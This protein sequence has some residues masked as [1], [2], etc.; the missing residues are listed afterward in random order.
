MASPII[1]HCDLFVCFALVVV[2]PILGV[3]WELT[4]LFQAVRSTFEIVS[5]SM[6]FSK[7]KTVEHYYH[8][9]SLN[10][11]S[12]LD[13]CDT[14]PRTHTVTMDGTQSKQV[15]CVFLFGFLLCVNWTRTSYPTLEPAS[16]QQC[17]CVR[18]LALR[19]VLMTLSNRPKLPISCGV[20]GE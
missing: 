16:L 5:T 19:L 10:I 18:A 3:L 12:N 11:Q 2:T 4:L 1:P 20:T 17:C 7:G 13:Y 15:N 14:M 6:L 8:A 9:K